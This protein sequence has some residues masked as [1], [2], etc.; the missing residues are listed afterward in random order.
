MRTK[1]LSR[2][3]VVLVVGIA[4]GFWRHH[5]AQGYYLQGREGFIAERGH[6]WDRFY[7]HPH[8]VV[9]GM[10]A[11]IIL[12]ALAFGAYELLV[13]GLSRLLRSSTDEKPS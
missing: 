5:A 13:A 9:T 6:N 7:A 12:A 8:H 2:I 11:N 3:I 10:V 1:L 4:L